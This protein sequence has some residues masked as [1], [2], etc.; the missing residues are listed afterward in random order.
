MS[1]EEFIEQHR[2]EVPSEIV[3]V[4]FTHEWKYE[5]PRWAAEHDPMHDWTCARC[6]IGFSLREGNN[7]WA[8]D[9]GK[10]VCKRVLMEEALG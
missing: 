6:D 8:E 10:Y 7:K 3:R 9:V 4:L 1:P 2:L 5:G